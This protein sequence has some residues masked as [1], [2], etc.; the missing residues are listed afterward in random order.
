MH[1][2][3]LVQYTLQVIKHSLSLLIYI[4]VFIYRVEGTRMINF[5]GTDL[6]C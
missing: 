3:T 6:N 1:A 4:K 5:F 2:R